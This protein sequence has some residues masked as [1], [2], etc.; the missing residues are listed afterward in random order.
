MPQ[1]TVRKTDLVCVSVCVCVWWCYLSLQYKVLPLPVLQH[2]E[3]LQ[4]ADDVHR[5]HRRLLA[6]LCGAQRL[7][8]VR[9]AASPLPASLAI[10]DR[11]DQAAARRKPL[12]N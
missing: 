1:W 2:L 7:T 10:T 9:E 6:D 5:V 4:G 8:S 12:V 3:G 11:N